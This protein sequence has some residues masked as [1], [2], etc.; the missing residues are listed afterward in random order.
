MVGARNGG[1]EATRC[2]VVQ[3]LLPAGGG[4]GAVR[5][6]SARG[7]GVGHDLLAYCFLSTFPPLDLTNTTGLAQAWPES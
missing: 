4:R 7:R 2:G 3:Q 1:H 6:G 5:R